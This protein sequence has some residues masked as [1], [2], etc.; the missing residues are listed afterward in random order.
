LLFFF[1]GLRTFVTRRS[2]PAEISP[3]ARCFTLT[4]NG[5]SFTL[6]FHCFTY[7][8]SLFLS[9]LLTEKRER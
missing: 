8:F 2:G 6:I 3:K 5:R 4:R 9:L 1:A 7:S